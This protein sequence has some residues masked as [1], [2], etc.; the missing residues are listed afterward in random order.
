[1]GCVESNGG[2]HTGRG[3]NSNGNGI[4]GKWVLDPF[5]D[6]N[7]NGKK[8]CQIQTFMHFAIATPQ[9][10]HPNW[11]PH[12]PFMKEKIYLVS[13]DVENLLRMNTCNIAVAIAVTQC[14]RALKDNS[15]HT[16]RVRTLQPITNIA[17]PLNKT[18]CTVVGLPT[19]ENLTEYL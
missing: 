16:H 7:G 19:N 1:M 2:V 11:I 8:L 14:E 3:G 17:G 6:G 10:E 13:V 9:C 4:V 12:N 18:G 15:K 5:C